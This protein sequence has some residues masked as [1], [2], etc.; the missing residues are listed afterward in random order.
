MT[1][2]QP[3]HEELLALIGKEYYLDNLSKVDI[4]QRYGIKLRSD[5]ARN[6]EIFASLNALSRYIAENRTQ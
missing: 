2:I 4:A 3:D 6:A 1:A 5:D